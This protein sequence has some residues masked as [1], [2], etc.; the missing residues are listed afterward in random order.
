MG[1]GNGNPTSLEKDQFIDNIELVTITNFEEKKLASANNSDQIS[2]DDN[3]WKE[4]FKD[5]DYKNQAPAYVYRGKF[6]L[7]NNSNTNTVNFFYKKIGTDAVVFVNGNKIA[8]S[9]EDNQ[10][11][12]LNANVSKQ[13]T[14]TIQIIAPPLQK[15]KDWDV[16]NTDPGIIQVITP[17]GQW[18]RKLFNGY[19][20]IIIQKEENA[21]EVVLSATANGLNAESLVVKK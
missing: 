9:S 13:G 18:K 8:S 12:V 10:K 20:Q 21:D 3:N 14:N 7:S 16:M 19:A 4:A 17:A 2:S 5:R 15:V 6:E 1:V 11:Y